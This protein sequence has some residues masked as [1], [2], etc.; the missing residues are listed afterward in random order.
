MDT[1]IIT[2]ESSRNIPLPSEAV[3]ALGLRAGSRLV[4]SVKD[5]AIHLQPLLAGDLDALCGIFSSQTD[6]V[7]ELQEER[8]QD[9]W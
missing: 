3:D 1:Q 8:R 6:L 2:L 4:L 7:A 5:G 9:Q